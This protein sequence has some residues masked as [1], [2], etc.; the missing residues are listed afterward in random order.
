MPRMR[1]NGIA[2]LLAGIFL[3][4]AACTALAQQVTL[5][6]PIGFFTNVAAR[7][8]RSELGVD[9]NRIQIYPTNQYTPAVHRL[10]QVTAN[11]YD[12]STNRAF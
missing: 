2:I 11:V 4:N 8:L 7:L 3:A 10:L 6:R 1:W 5:E 9:L 12:A